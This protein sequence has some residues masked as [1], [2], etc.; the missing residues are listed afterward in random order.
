MN[1]NGNAIKAP[2]FYQLFDI[3]IESEGGRSEQGGLG[4]VGRVGARCILYEC[5]GHCSLIKM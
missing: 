3:C 1:V 2:Y 4:R 5:L